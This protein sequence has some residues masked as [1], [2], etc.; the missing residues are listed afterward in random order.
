MGGLHLVVRSGTKV[1]PPIG[2]KIGERV[3]GNPTAIAHEDDSVRR[4]HAAYRS[5]RLPNVLPRY[6]RK[7]MPR[8]ISPFPSTRLPWTTAG[9]KKLP[10]DG[11][12]VH[13]VMTS[14]MSSGNGPPTR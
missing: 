4:S 12:S 6:S 11:L 7:W 10:W 14:A 13:T 5:E 8:V 2:M 3:K 1:W 9:E